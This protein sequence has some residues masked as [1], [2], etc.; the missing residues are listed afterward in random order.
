MNER[1]VLTKEEF[2]KR[3]KDEPGVKHGSLT[4]LT[5]EPIKAGEEVPLENSSRVRTTAGRT[6]YQCQCDCGKTTW[7]TISYW[8][9]GYARSCGK[10]FEPAPGKKYNK[11]TVI[12]EA[13]SQPRTFPNGKVYSRRFWKCKCDCGREAVV[14]Q[15]HLISGH[16]SSCGYCTKKKRDKIPPELRAKMI[17]VTTSIISRCTNPYDPQFY[18]YGGRGIECRLGKTPVDAAIKLLSVP[19]YKEGLEIDRINN[20]GDYEVSNLRWVTSSENH[21]NRSVSIGMNKDQISFRPL[22]K[23]TF[24][25]ICFNSKLKEDE[26][27]CIKLPDEILRLNPAVP[28]LFIYIHISN[29]D[30]TRFYVK[31]IL[32][33]WS[34]WTSVS[35]VVTRPTD[36]VISEGGFG[37]NDITLTEVITSDVNFSNKR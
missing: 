34:K 21:F 17:A 9:N 27:I 14:A 11:L 31:R 37:E 32:D 28:E 30:K 35:Y 12:E 1:N 26:F 3:Y 29:K 4:L 15:D 23:T 36:I 8:R 25:S 20:D 10:C 13:P 18:N 6:M 7:V 22:T 24:S 19:G 5:T 2:M 16:T 33:F